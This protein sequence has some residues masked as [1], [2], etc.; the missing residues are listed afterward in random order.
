MVRMEITLL[1]ASFNISQTALIDKCTVPARM[2]ANETFN[3][4]TNCPESSFEDRKKV[5][6]AFLRHIE[7]L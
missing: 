2:D 1:P 5:Q 3:D 4:H 7:L 6:L